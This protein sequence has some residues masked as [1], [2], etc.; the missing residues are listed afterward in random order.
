MEM[1]IWTLLN[2]LDDEEMPVGKEVIDGCVLEFLPKR[3]RNSSKRDFGSTAIVAG[4]KKYTGAAVLAARACLRSGTGSTVMYVPGKLWG[5]YVGLVP[6]AILVPVGE[7]DVFVYSEEIM[8]D[9]MRHSAVAIGMGM[10]VSKDVYDAIRYLIDNYTGKLLIDADGLNSI[11]EYTTNI[12]EEFKNAK[13]K[14]LLTPNNWEFCRLLKIKEE[15][16]TK[17]KG[18]YCPGVQ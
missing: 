7:D 6:E 11:A 12:F 10:G 16:L 4:S 8:K 15:D 1:D 2:E 9:I 13:C 17:K 18:R 5:H 3:P 14:I